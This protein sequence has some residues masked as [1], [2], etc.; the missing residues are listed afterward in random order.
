MA[1]AAAATRF[2]PV[3]AGTRCAF[4]ASPD[5]PPDSAGQSLISPS[6]WVSAAIP[7]VRLDRAPDAPLSEGRGR[8]L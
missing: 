2:Y 5:A 3:C 8:F 6:G 1:A 7:G 4:L